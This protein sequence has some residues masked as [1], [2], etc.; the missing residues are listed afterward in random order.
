M[1]EVQ[2]RAAYRIK[3]A[4]LKQTREKMRDFQQNLAKAEAWTHTCRL[5]PAVVLC[6][7]FQ[8]N[9]LATTVD[10]Q[11]VKSNISGVSQVVPQNEDAYNYLVEETQMTVFQDGTTALFDE[12]IA[13]FVSDAGWCHLSCDWELQ[14]A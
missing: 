1:T 8:S 2:I 9:L 6:V 3:A 12:R 4:L 5:T 14:A 10:F 13:D 7:L 11:I